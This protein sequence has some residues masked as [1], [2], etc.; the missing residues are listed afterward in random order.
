MDNSWPTII[1][2]LRNGN[3]ESARQLIELTQNVLYKY[4]FYLSG[5]QQLSEDISHDTYLKA[6]KNIGQLKDPEQTTAWLKK[7]AKNLFLDYKKSAA[8]S[9]PHVDFE[10]CLDS[11]HSRMAAGQSMGPNN[12]DT[13][14]L[15][16]QALQSL[17]DE[18]RN[19]VI[20]VDIEGHSYA[21]VSSS[22]G[23]KE[24]TVKSKV[25]RARKKILEYIETIS[26]AESSKLY[27]KKVE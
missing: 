18:D 22:L 2:G 21:E 23:M 5:N 10:E 1:R 15:A 3:E 7:I 20:L 12:P 6:L 27:K 9:K 16:M 17:D 11:E 24:G 26:P 4:V 8:Q 19:L 13:Q 14:I 25:F